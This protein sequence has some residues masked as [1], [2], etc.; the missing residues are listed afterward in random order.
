MSWSA[1]QYV[2]FEE[3]RTRPARDLL[4]AVPP[5][6]VGFAIDIGCGP[7]NST[8][9]IAARF[10]NARI[11]GIDS[12]K[13]MVEAAR[14]RLP[15]LRFEVADIRAWACDPSDDPGENSGPA[16]LIFANAV[17]QWVPGHAELFPALATRL[18]TGGCLAVQ[19]PDNLDEP[20]HTLMREI[21]EEGPWRQKLAGADRS[22]VRIE[23]AAWYYRLLRASCSRVDVWRTTYHHPLAGAGA[24]VEWFKGTGLLPFLAPLDAAERAGYLDRYTRAIETAYPAVDGVVLLPFPRLFVVANRR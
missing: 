18:S 22:R 6:A 21:A 2:A 16:D 9:L 12:S 13:D 8:E 23:P 10:P 20:A 5:G 19:V 24:I 11:T 7:G 4:A 14:L 17:L 1:K 3:E 15:A